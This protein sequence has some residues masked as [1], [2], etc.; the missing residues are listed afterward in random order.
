MA[1]DCTEEIQA[2]VLALRG[3]EAEARALAAEAL[4]AI[5][6]PAVAPLVELLSDGSMLIRHRATD[7]LARIGPP[8]IL[9]LIEVLQHEDRHIRSVA[10]L[11]LSKMGDAESLPRRILLDARLQPTLRSATLE[12]LRDVNYRDRE[13]RLRYPIPDAC[14]YC[15]RMLREED[16]DVR[17]AAEAVLSSQTLLRPGARDHATERETLL[18]GAQAG[19]ETT[20]PEVLLRASDDPAKE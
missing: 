15:R 7:A 11:T 9:R 4:A 3:D 6:G 1:E 18:R 2:L 17:A 10:A 5:G 12:S 19:G 16:A 20:A 13:V 8:A 14:T